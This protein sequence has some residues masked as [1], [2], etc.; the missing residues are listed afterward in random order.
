MAKTNGKNKGHAAKCKAYKDAKTRERNK[1]RKAAKQAKRMMRFVANRPA[2]LLREYTKK[3]ARIEERAA[4][5][6]KAGIEWKKP[7]IRPP[8]VE[9]DVA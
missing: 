7:T 6:A 5:Y 9:D 8:V 3:M 4:A 2:R 1:A